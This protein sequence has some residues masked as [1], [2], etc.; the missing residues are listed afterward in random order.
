MPHLLV[1]VS[2]HGFG[3]AAQASAVVNAL[4]GRMPDLAVT[5]RTTVPQPFLESRFRPPVRF[6]READDFGMVQC[7]ALEVDRGASAG[8]YRTFHSDWD[9]RV[10]R[11]ARVIA[12]QEPDLI[13]ADV[14]YLT[15]AAADR[16]GLPAVG[17]CCL[18]WA[19]IYRH[20]FAGTEGA[21]VIHAQMLAAY[22]S[23][24]A[25]LRT[26][27]AMP[28]EALTNLRTIGPIMRPAAD[29]REAI[30]VRAGLR[31]GERLV[32][33]AMGGIRS[34]PPMEAWP[35]LPQVRWVVQRDWGVH[36][37][38][39]LVIEELGFSFGEVL[40]SADALVTKPGYGS[41]SEA[42]A[43]G[44]PVLSVMRRDWPESPYL[45]AWLAQRVPFVR[46]GREV[47]ERGEFAA[48]LLGLLERGRAEPVLPTGIE[49]AVDCLLSHLG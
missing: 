8:A 39:T 25:F 20:Y 19:D 6:D 1:A 9:A 46:I 3:H 10:A 48:E 12:E 45:E 27:P 5:V 49:E 24:A 32:V 7:D 28:M 23:A 43:Y 14:P 16:L 33:V 22:N 31:D 34:R 35:A 4:R 13:L 17:M 21:D 42:A 38:D 36:R 44:L 18:N 26:E 2:P 40:A 47:F 30:R 29:R 15:L 41:F 37:S 11:T